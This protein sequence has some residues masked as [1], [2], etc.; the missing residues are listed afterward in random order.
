MKKRVYS[1]EYKKYNANNRG[2]NVGDCVNRAISLA[3]NMD[4]NDIHKRLLDRMHQMN[5]NSWKVWPIYEAVIYDLSDIVSS[6]EVIDDITVSEFIDKYGPVGTYIIE[7]SNKP[8]GKH[9]GNHLTCAIDGVLYDSWDSSREFVCSYYPISTATTAREFTNIQEN[10]DELR[11]YAYDLLGKESEK[12]GQ[13]FRGLTRTLSVEHYMGDKT[14]EF[15]PGKV[16]GLSIKIPC[17]YEI[18]AFEKTHKFKFTVSYVFNPSTTL[19]EAKKYIEKL[20]KVRIYDRFYE[21]KKKMDSYEEEYNAKKE[22]EESGQTLTPISHLALD[23]V[24][25]K[26][27]NTLPGKIRPRIDYLL[28]DEVRRYTVKFKPLP[29]DFNNDSVVLE[30]HNPDTIRKMIE[31]YMDDYSRPHQD[32]DPNDEFPHDSF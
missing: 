4:Y 22:M 15:L 9:H 25:M 2:K 3:F 20:T 16:D 21:M 18:E 14:D 7:T 5:Y 32:Y 29:G 23:S 28:I 31:W 13:R 1:A 24:E 17:M 26:F 11:E 30:A 8:Y 12:Q 10:F 6:K 19:E 27:Y